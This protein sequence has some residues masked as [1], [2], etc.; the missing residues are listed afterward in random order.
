VRE[1][2]RVKER[3]SERWGGLLAR[4]PASTPHVRHFCQAH[5]ATLN[6]PRRTDPRQQTP[7]DHQAR[8]KQPLKT[9]LHPFPPLGRCWTHETAI[10]VGR[11]LPNSLPPN[12]YREY[13]AP[14]YSLN[15]AAHK[16]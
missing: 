7:A 13:Y 10:L 9:P 2:E 3:V 14:D 16:V 6:R 15:V 11:R 5:Q 1:R 8:Q 12:D 4:H